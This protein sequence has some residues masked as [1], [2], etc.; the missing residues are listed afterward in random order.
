MKEHGN[1]PKTSN[2]IVFRGKKMSRQM[3]FILYV[4]SCQELA[5]DKLTILTP[6]ESHW[7]KAE[8]NTFEKK[9]STE[10]EKKNSLSK[11]FTGE[12]STL[13]NEGVKNTLSNLMMQFL[14]TKRHASLYQIMNKRMESKLAEDMPC[15]TIDILTNFFGRSS[16]NVLISPQGSGKNWNSKLMSK[17]GFLFRLQPDVVSIA[18]SSRVPSLNDS[19]F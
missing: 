17:N 4:A 12:D 13:W 2:N 18:G 14:K 16:H 10:T 9:S 11:V 7:Y 5:T 1:E 8:K 3:M 19:C 6:C 15:V